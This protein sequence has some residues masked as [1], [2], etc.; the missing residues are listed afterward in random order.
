[1]DFDYKINR[2]GLTSK[3]FM[4]GPIPNNNIIYKTTQEEKIYN[5]GDPKL[6]V[7]PKI[8]KKEYIYIGIAS[9]ILIIIFSN[10]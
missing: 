1:M 6:A 3:L 10:K 9:V 5:L 7:M 2:T 8:I 4:H